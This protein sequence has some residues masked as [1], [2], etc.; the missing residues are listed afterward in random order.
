MILN[1]LCSSAFKMWVFTLMVKD[2]ALKNHTS[3]EVVSLS[4]LSTLSLPGR[5]SQF[6]TSVS[7]VFSKTY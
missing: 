5:K 2:R 1:P 3:V 4:I 6:G 7:S